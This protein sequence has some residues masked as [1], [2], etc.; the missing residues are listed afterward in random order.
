MTTWPL[1][2]LA[3]VALGGLA[4]CDV[5][6][7]A[8]SPPSAA[9]A[10]SGASSSS[11]AWVAVRG[12]SSAAPE[13]YPARILRT[14]ESEAVVVAP[15]PARIASVLKKPGDRVEKGDPVVIVVMPELDAAG[16]TVAAA[17]A[18]LAVLEARKERLT[19]LA[20]EGLVREAELSDLELELARHRA[21]RLRGRA[22]LQS[23]EGPGGRVMLRSPL[24]GVLYEVAAT[25][26]ELRRPDDGP[27]ARIRAK[28]G[29]RV[30][31][32]LARAPSTDATYRLAAGGEDI[33]LSLIN[34]IAAPSGL[35]HLA[36]FEAGADVELPAANEGSLRV[37][38]EGDGRT[39]R[40]VPT[41]AVGEA[42]GKHFVVVRAKAELPAKRL[43]V[44][45]AR[46]VGA[47]ALIR[48]ELEE[49]QLVATAPGRAAAELEGAVTP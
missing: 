33:S 32:T 36:W 39:L 1:R 16:A 40:A 25:L 6:S 3:A 49:G 24:A 27:L 2:V 8:S 5:G 15:L 22:V 20:K 14:G 42:A 38:A 19:S 44:E 10:N 37:G 41:T 9:A 4:S 17:E 34:H 26:G 11:Y 13:E 12:G 18:S 21:D 43:E 45:L 31:A 46:V 48:G 30:E 29:Q 28:A 7:S 23:A 47:D 35:G